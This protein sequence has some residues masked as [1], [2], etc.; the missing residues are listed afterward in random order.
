MGCCAAGMPNSNE[1]MGHKKLQFQIFVTTIF[2]IFFFP[3]VSLLLFPSVCEMVQSSHKMIK[4][5]GGQG[6]LFWFPVSIVM[7]GC[8]AG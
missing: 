2:Y 3:D 6:F 4:G 7:P 8:Q 5:I 1:Q